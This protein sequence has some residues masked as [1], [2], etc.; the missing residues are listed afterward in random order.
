MMCSIWLELLWLII[1]LRRKKKIEGDSGDL[2][3]EMLVRKIN[4]GYAYVRYVCMSICMC[5]YIYMYVE[6]CMCVIRVLRK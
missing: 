5:M 3:S 1:Q 2:M 4:L 6:M